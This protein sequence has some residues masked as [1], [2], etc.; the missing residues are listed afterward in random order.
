MAWCVPQAC[1]LCS[2]VAF[3]LRTRVLR[4][5]LD[6]IGV[7]LLAPLKQRTY[8]D[9]HPF[10]RPFFLP[11]VPTGVTLDYGTPDFVAM[12]E[13]GFKVFKDSAFVLVA[14]G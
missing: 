14:G 9:F 2:C 13:K 10:L 3:I 8:T 7:S 11:Q 6:W 1:R 4:C 12:E 5:V